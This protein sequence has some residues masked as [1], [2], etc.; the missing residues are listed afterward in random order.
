MSTSATQ[1]SDKQK[2]CNFKGHY[3]N[4]YVVQLVNKQVTS[5]TVIFMT[6]FHTN[7]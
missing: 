4:Q 1:R 3:Q 2:L 6:S 5:V 7:K